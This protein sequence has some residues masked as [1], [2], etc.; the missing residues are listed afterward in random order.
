MDPWEGR[1][2][3]PNYKLCISSIHTMFFSKKHCTV[4][5]QPVAKILTKCTLVGLKWPVHDLLPLSKLPAIQGHAQNL[6]EQLG[7]EGRADVIIISQRCMT[8]SALK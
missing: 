2:K 6:Q 3:I 7:M 1:E 4:T 5:L 8:S